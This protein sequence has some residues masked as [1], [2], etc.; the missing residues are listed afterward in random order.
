MCDMLCFEKMKGRCF[1]LLLIGMA[2][3]YAAWII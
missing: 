2:Y 1:T 3:M